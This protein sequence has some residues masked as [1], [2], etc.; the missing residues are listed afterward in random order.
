MQSNNFDADA[1]VKVLMDQ[2][3]MGQRQ[4]NAILDQVIPGDD[5]YWEPLGQPTGKAKLTDVVATIEVNT[6]ERVERRYVVEIREADCDER[7]ERDMME[8]DDEEIL[9]MAEEKVRNGDVHKFTE[10]NADIDEVLR[11]EKV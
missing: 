7:R 10:G 11:V 1:M 9:V 2:F 3:N 5:P 6:V 8:I 4:A